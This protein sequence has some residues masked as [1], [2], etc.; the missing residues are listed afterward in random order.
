[1]LRENSIAREWA[2]YRETKKKVAKNVAV[3]LRAVKTVPKWFFLKQCAIILET[4]ANLLNL[5]SNF[6]TNLLFSF[7]LILI[8]LPSESEHHN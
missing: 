1:M 2:S 6:E 8:C 4:S 3:I 5:R 7:I